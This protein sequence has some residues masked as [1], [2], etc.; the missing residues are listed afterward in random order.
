MTTR[1]VVVEAAAAAP[2]LKGKVKL[3]PV[4]ASLAVGSR[5][6]A[7]TAQPLIVRIPK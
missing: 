6:T 3:K 2:G 5:F 1:P 7:I 4:D